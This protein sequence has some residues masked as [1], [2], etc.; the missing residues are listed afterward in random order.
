[1]GQK[2]EAVLKRLAEVKAEEAEIQVTKWLQQNIVDRSRQIQG[3]FEDASHED[4]NREPVKKLRSSSLDNKQNTNLKRKNS[5][6]KDQTLHKD[7]TETADNDT[8]S[9]LG[10]R[11]S[12]LT[13]NRSSAPRVRSKSFSD[14]SCRSYARNFQDRIERVEGKQK[15]MK[16]RFQVAT[17]DKKEICTQMAGFGPPAPL[18]S[19][20][21]RKEKREEFE[22]HSVKSYNMGS[23]STFNK[24]HPGMKID[25]GTSSSA[26]TLQIDVEGKVKVSMNG[27]C[28]LQDLRAR[29]C[30]V[31]T[32]SPLWMLK[33]SLCKLFHIN[34][35]TSI[36]IRRRRSSAISSSGGGFYDLYLQSPK[37]I[38]LGDKLYIVGTGRSREGLHPVSILEDSQKTFPNGSTS[39][40]DQSSR[41]FGMK[42]SFDKTGQILTKKKCQPKEVIDMSSVE[43]KEAFEKL[44]IRT[45][46]LGDCRRL[47]EKL[48]NHFSSKSTN[49]K[50]TPSSFVAEVLGTTPEDLDIWVRNEMGL[51][52]PEEGLINC[53]NS[54][55]NSD[56]SW[57]EPAA[58]E[59]V[60][61]KDEKST[62]SPEEDEIESISGLQVNQNQLNNGDRRVQVT[63][64][65]K[66]KTQKKKKSVPPL[67]INFGDCL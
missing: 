37:Q 25:P 54:S 38:E 21:F 18:P 17:F 43:M 26:N 62:T 41:S 36:S 28:H 58:Q 50:T 3:R 42:L 49:P 7:I 9:C 20:N 66:L 24:F 31:D 22:T 63:G 8:L 53:E 10:S 13:E 44:E 4:N 1:V 14:Q 32:E 64:S 61:A 34:E 65:L 39:G 59:F 67:Y 12:R 27:N 19:T 52:H 60:K 57:D 45:D 55:Q 47:R 51:P 48:S 46:A 40:S 35:I 33:H 11:Q 5:F 16:P 15:L 29:T 30:L 56:R 23:V 2:K 6:A